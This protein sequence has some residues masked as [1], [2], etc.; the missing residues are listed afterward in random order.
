M[1][2]LHAMIE[3]VHNQASLF[4]GGNLNRT[5]RVGLLF[6]CLVLSGTAHLDAQAAGARATTRAEIEASI[7]E[8][9]KILTSSGYSSRLKNAKRKEVQLLRYRLVEG[10]LQ[11]GDRILLSVQGEATLSD[12]FTVGP[13]RTLTLPAIGD[14]PL[15][16]VLRSELEEH[17]TTQ[18]RKYLKDPVVRAQTTLRLSFLGSVGR[19]GY[20][21]V[22]SEMMIGDAIMAAGGPGGGIDPAKT[23][24]V[25]NDVEIMSKEAF[26]KALQEGKTLDQLSLLA[27]DEIL[28]GG[29]RI[30]QERGGF[31]NRA[32]PAITG[33]LSF[34]FL[35]VQIL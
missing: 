31:F 34:T 28:V 33:A 20:Y 8:A 27:G 24:I 12:S 11:Q 17:L 16:G 2:T 10:D 18:L 15:K 26:T 30:A 6:A 23:R 3:D 13:R 19:P 32:L 14:I 7:V 35:I 25:R 29:E 5:S 4:R 1:S 22:A 21:Q 9:D